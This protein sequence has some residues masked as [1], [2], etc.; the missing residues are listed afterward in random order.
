MRYLRSYEYGLPQFNSVPDAEIE[1]VDGDP[2]ELQE[3]Q[4]LSD[5]NSEPSEYQEK[6]PPTDISET[7]EILEQEDIMQHPQ[8]EIT[9]IPDTKSRNISSLPMA[10]SS[11][12][13]QEQSLPTPEPPLE[14]HQEA[15]SP[16]LHRRTNTATFE[17]PLGGD[18][19]RIIDASQPSVEPRKPNQGC[20]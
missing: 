8:H 14:G 20:R 6:E 10:D 16:G 19:N 3:N 9:E 15:L 1:S 4:N 12:W 2:L 7:T 18:G 17:M 11:G 5:L 13:S